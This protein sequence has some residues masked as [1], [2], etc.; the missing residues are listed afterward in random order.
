MT[1]NRRTT[2][3]RGDWVRPGR[4]YGRLWAFGILTAAIL[5]GIGYLLVFSPV[6]WVDQVKVEG[7]R[8][9]S[10]EELRKVVYE[11]G[12]RSFGP[13]RTRSIF[14]IDRG[15][16]SAQVKES[17]TEV[18]TAEVTTKLPDTVVLSVTERRSTLFWKTGGKAYLV[19]QRGIAYEEARSDKGLLTVEDSTNLPVTVGKQVVG[20]TFITVLE[21]IRQSLKDRGFKVVGF[22]IPETTFEVQAV[23]ADGWYALFDTTRPVKSQ[24]DAL[25]LAVKR[26]RPYQYADLRVPGRVYVR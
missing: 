16:V 25:K 2:Y 24:A 1:G 17:V 18:A 26:E 14:L 21:D 12:E 22:R 10:A 9:L 19:D 15:N 20:A 11:A 8:A 5:A 13:L 6:F 7:V 3:R 23:T 4:G